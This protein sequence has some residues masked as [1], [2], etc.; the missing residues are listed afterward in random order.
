MA[1]DEGTPGIPSLED[2]GEMKEGLMEHKKG[3]D[4]RSGV[5]VECK[6]GFN[7]RSGVFVE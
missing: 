5:F 7:P 1:R 2:D 6:K 3:F 4:P